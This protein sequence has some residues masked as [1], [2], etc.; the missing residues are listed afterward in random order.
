MA[1]IWCAGA[2]QPVHKWSPCTNPP[3]PPA[4]RPPPRYHTADKAS[5]MPREVHIPPIILHPDSSVHLGSVH[6]GREHSGAACPACHD[7]SVGGGSRHGSVVL[8]RGGEAAFSRVSLQKHMEYGD[9]EGQQSSA[10]P[11]AEAEAA[12]E[13]EAAAALRRRLECEF[14]AAEAEAAAAAQPDLE[15]GGG[16]LQA[17]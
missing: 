7:C 12:E 16:S 1:A 8:V 5:T 4:L 15:R 3:L 10:M 17:P 6:G 11:T 14:L 13:E 2:V 9:G